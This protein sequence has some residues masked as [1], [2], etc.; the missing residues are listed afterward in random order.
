MER[1]SGLGPAFESRDSGPR[2]SASAEVALRALAA[3]AVA[4]IATSCGLRAATASDESARSDAAS[5]FQQ[6]DANT[7]GFVTS[8]EVGQEKQRLLARLLRTAD[9]DK[10]GKLNKDEFVA[11]LK[12]PEAASAR[13]GEATGRGAGPDP[14]AFF[15]RMDRNGDGKVTADEIPEE[16]Q[17]GFSRMRDFADV[18]GDGA[19]DREEFAKVRERFAGQA[20]GGPAQGP[21]A[22]RGEPSKAGEAIF[23]V[24]D[25]NGDGKLS[26]DEIAKAAESLA[27]LDRNGDGSINLAELDPS[28][29]APVLAAAGGPDPARVWQ[30]LLGGD[31]NGDGKL[32]EDE[33]PERFA[34]AFGR[35]DRNGDGVIDETEFKTGLER[36]R[37]AA[38]GERP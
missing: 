32:S 28:R 10:D 22:D 11:G 15:R 26:S 33:L 38:R 20:L 30:R 27:A 31:K 14:N 37:G 6:L 23:R 36:L 16:R 21:A 12:T 25:K 7:D 4:A 2:I 24:L 18:N 9:S 1:T 19:V 5:L 3:L 8:D 34:R 35:I 29:G 17:E 13:S